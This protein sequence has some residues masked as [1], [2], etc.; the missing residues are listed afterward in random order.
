MMVPS[1]RFWKLRVCFY[2]AHTITAVPMKKLFAWVYYCV[3]VFI[4]C[5]TYY[6]VVHVCHGVF[7]ALPTLSVCVFITAE[8]IT[9]L[10]A[11]GE[12]D[13]RGHVLRE[14]TSRGLSR[15]VC[16]SCISERGGEGYFKKKEG[17]GEGELFVITAVPNTKLCVWRI[18]EDMCYEIR[19]SESC[20]D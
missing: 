18:V 6:K 4:T 20:V 3:C 1:S 12:G 9:K 10:F 13:S 19:R 14:T 8:P 15:L 5:S 7:T 16:P 2:Y 17:K 11:W